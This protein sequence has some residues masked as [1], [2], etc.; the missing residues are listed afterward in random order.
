MRPCNR[1]PGR[2]LGPVSTVA[3]TDNACA[4]GVGDTGKIF[5]ADSRKTAFSDAR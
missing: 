3:V 2:L 1:F 5:N 4:V